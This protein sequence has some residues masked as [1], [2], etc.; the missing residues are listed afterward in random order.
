MLLSL[1]EYLSEYYSGFNV[2]QYLTLR[3]ILGVLT[4]LVLSFV[5]GP[6]MI[7]WLGTYNMGQPVRDDG[8]QTHLS[9]AGTPTM[10]G[11]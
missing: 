5:I 8:P 4:A 7:Q 2:F 1:F 3:A 9:T 6:R 10:G 11:R